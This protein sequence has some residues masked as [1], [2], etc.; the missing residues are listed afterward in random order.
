MR[1][2]IR[3]ERR[4]E[5]AF[6]NK[7][8]FDIVRWREGNK[9]LN[10]QCHGMKISYSKVNGEIVPKYERVNLVKKVF[11]ENKNYLL[12]VPQSAINKNP[13][14]YPNNPGW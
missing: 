7:R 10:Q 3:R 4:I 2:R 9:Y 6:E 11:D 8:Y 1:E 14:L 12:P 13:K 5:L